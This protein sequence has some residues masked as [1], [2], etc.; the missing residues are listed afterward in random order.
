MH[1][2]Y[3]T[4]A[5]F[6]DEEPIVVP[7]VAPAFAPDGPVAAAL[8]GRYRHRPGQ[9]K[10]AQLVR[11]ALMEGRPALIEAGTGSGKSFA[12]LIPLVLSGARGLISTANKTLQTQL[13]EKDIPMLRDVLDKDF[14]A[15][16]LKGH[17]NYVC[18]LKMSDAR[19]QMTLSGFLDE[20][21]TLREKLKDCRS[22][23]VEELGVPQNLREAV[24]ARPHEC[25]GH[26]CP[27]VARCYYEQARLKAEESDI[28]V[29]N[30]ALFACCLTHAIL[31]PRPVVIID[32]A[33]ELERYVIDAL[34][35]ELRYETVLN[36]VN[37]NVVMRHVPESVRKDVVWTNKDFFDFLS[38]KPT[39]E[40]RRWAVQREL[41]HGTRLA[42]LLNDVH[43]HLL[44]A[45]PPVVDDEEGANEENARHQLT[46]EWVEGLADEV[47]ALAEEAPADEVRYCEEIVPGGGVESVV[48]RQEPTDVAGFLRDGQASH[49]HRCDFDGGERLRIPEA[50]DWST[51]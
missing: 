37:D 24:T 33:H 6:A 38:E 12:Y 19:K 10:M 2:D 26:S 3:D 9:V 22:G 49:L 48:L 42:G 45:Y 11:K 20:I 43:R 7:D 30:H 4:I 23:D 17:K 40:E 15:A 39:G 36:L 13:W 27:Y 31:S 21:T 5:S 46:M 32:E 28:V 29:V 1:N 50:A 16:L 47:T 44:K 25:L 18:R 35:L 41:D 51:G 14:S 34:C 8:G